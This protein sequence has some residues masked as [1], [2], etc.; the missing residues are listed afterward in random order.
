MNENSQ[1]LQ[2]FY[3]KRIAE[4]GLGYTAMWGDPG[5][6]KSAVRFSPL[7]SLP[8]KAGESLIDIGCGIGD[9][10]DHL[11]KSVPCA[12]DYTGV[13][14][15]PEFA[16]VARKR[17]GCTILEINAFSHLDELPEADWY[18]SFGTL[19]KDW[20][21]ADLPGETSREKIFRLTERLHE[22]AR[23][24]FAITLV[25]DC[26]DHRKHGT[27]NISPAELADHIGKL[28]PFFMIYHG[29]PFFEFFAAG[30]KSQ[31]S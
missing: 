8:F 12:L 30:W 1:E 6:W 9:L 27:A 29:Y 15:V 17:T 23:K 22:K 2:H 3:G 20:C 13:E 21:L 5:E 25:T 18:V 26:V 7:S 4:H 28:T 24:G 31:R 10:H 16:E 14:I 11:K 19:N